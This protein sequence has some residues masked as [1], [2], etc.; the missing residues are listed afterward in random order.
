MEMGNIEVKH[1]VVSYSNL[2]SCYSKE[3]YGGVL[4]KEYLTYEL[5]QG[6]LIYSGS[7]MVRYLLLHLRI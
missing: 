4:V 6:R 7:K 2:I 1:D 3:G 5:L